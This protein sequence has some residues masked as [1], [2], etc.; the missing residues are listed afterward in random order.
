MVMTFEISSTAIQ[1]AMEF[2]LGTDP[3]ALVTLIA[4]F[5]RHSAITTHPEGNRRYGGY[6]LDIRDFKVYTLEHY[7]PDRPVCPECHGTGHHRRRDGRAWA[8]VS[9]SLC[10]KK[11]RHDVAKGFEERVSA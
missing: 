2:G 6:V 9:C 4:N 11:E 7:N 8:Y 5:A 10:G 1:R 3:E